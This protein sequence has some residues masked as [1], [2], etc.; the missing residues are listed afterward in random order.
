[1]RSKKDKVL[2]KISLRLSADVIRSSDTHERI[3]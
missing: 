1:M 2:G 3:L